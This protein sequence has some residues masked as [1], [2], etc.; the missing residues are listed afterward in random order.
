M[1]SPPRRFPGTLFLFVSLLAI[2]VLA[3]A[4]RPSEELPLQ[5]AIR[6]Q[7]EKFLAA[8]L[9][10]DSPAMLAVWAPQAAGA[11]GFRQSQESFFS[12]AEK[13]AIDKPVFSGWA[14]GEK[15]EK[16]YVRV[17]FHRTWTAFKTG[18][19]QTEPVTWDLLWEETGGEWRLR[20]WSDLVAVLAIAMVR[21]P[22]REERAKVVAANPDA[23]VSTLVRQLCGAAVGFGQLGDWETAYRC[24]D[25]EREAAELI[26]DEKEAGWALA[27][28]A[29]LHLARAA[30]A[31]AETAWR[32]AESALRKAGDGSGAVLAR[33]NRAA[34]IA[35]LG[36]Y[37]EA[38][39]LL[40]ECARELRAADR[41]TRLVNALLNRGTVLFRLGRYREAADV[42]EDA[43]GIAKKEEFLWGG[44]LALT[45][46]ANLQNATGSYDRALGNYQACLTVARERQMTAEELRITN[47]I[48][49]VMVAKG[50]TRAALPVYTTALDLARKVGDREAEA[51]L[52]T[53]LASA[54][55][56][57]GQYGEALAHMDRALT[58][59]R[60]Q[61]AREGEAVTL[62]NMGVLYNLT[63][64]YEESLRA[65]QQSLEI[66]SEI[67]ARPHQMTALM[68]IALYHMHRGDGRQ[69][70]E[71]L[72]SAHLL[73][74]ELGDR[75]AQMVAV[76]NLGHMLRQIGDPTTALAM[77]KE[78]LEIARE[79]RD[80]AREAAAL[81]S[82][83]R[84]QAALGKAA[85]A[86]ASFEAAARLAEQCGDRSLMM[87]AKRGLGEVYDGQ[88]RWKEAAAAYRQAAAV[89][90]SLR[91]DAR[92]QTLQT[93][94]FAQYSSTYFRLARAV[95]EQ[96][97]PA[98]AFAAS[99]R[100][101]ARA[102]VD[103]LR[104]SKASVSR[105]LSA[106]ERDE[107]A[108]LEAQVTS[109]TAE[110]QN[111]RAL[112]TDRVLAIRKEVDSGRAK[113]EE[114]QRRLFVRHP[115]L[116]VRRGQFSPAGLSELNRK[117]FAGRPGLCV[118]AYLA[119]E[120]ETLL[121]VLS[122]GKAPAGPASLA[123][124]RL[125]VPFRALTEDAGQFRAAC[126]QA[127]ETYRPLAQNLFRQLVQPA[128][129]EVAGKTHL[130]VVPD[131]AMPVLPFQALLDGSGKHLL[132]RWSLSYAPSVTAL[133]AMMELRDSRRR[134][135]APRVT[136]LAAGRPQLTSLP[137]LEAAE[138]EVRALAAMAGAGARA[139]TGKEASERRVRAEMGDA[140]CIHLATHGLL[141]EVAPLYSALALTRS[142]ADDGLLEAR[143]VLALDLR[144]DLVVLSACETGLGKGV[145]G[146]GVL[147]LTWAFFVAG[148]PATVVSQWQV[149]DTSTGALMRAFYAG[150][151]KPAKGAPALPR[152]GALRAAQLRLLRDGAHGH[153]YYW[154]PFVLVGD[155]R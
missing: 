25:L 153:P 72:R 108:R 119:G 61:K 109:V 53:N 42:L 19:S 57:L 70:S 29:D 73:A 47:N 46:L 52:S 85:E 43:C 101:R 94:F 75:T 17:R 79:A 88:K 152:A 146:E 65:H 64:R 4:A 84:S 31:E 115:E 92:E 39:G 50:E 95:H 12:G 15:D 125:P 150:F 2:G 81:D 74:N 37:A 122:A 3:P 38:L 106:Q 141:N 66:A 128:A 71:A 55:Q 133:V 123:V 132:E 23:A 49:L 21:A 91:A 100:A 96:G 112:P 28:R 116:Q 22:S 154:A 142:D 129:R 62:A 20:E 127:G 135:P 86:A 138:Q 143:E 130:V 144:A 18:E 89:L 98:G 40:E 68:G 120:A 60:E 13:L 103:L 93:S 34:T 82:I 126:G 134:Q 24:N 97:D 102:L 121:F 137:D 114:F 67:G 58:S 27:T 77:G 59:F 56:E 10:R 147:G 32:E 78:A 111:S 107:E 7:V 6:Q 140:R 14:V 124:Y 63:G 76:L 83:G 48:A 90:E 35:N 87:H 105:G 1:P 118:L 113:L 69:A 45:N 30:Y 54:C 110:L 9:R 148:A 117:L 151:L 33:S 5:S 8:W 26:G 145:G 41:P 36:R 16:A 155:W 44:I 139:Y 11:E 80:T 104:R 131:P 149:E 136:L 99:E 51:Q